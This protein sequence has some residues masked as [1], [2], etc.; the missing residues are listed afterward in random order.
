[1]R[2]EDDE[3]TAG[4]PS[5]RRVMTAAAVATAA[6]ATGLGTGAA[7]ARPEGGGPRTG[8][9]DT[10]HHALP[11]DM[12]KWAVDHGLLPREGGPNWGR[13]DLNRTLDT[14]DDLGIAAG[15]A[16]AP[17]PPELFR[18]RRLAAS[19]TRVFN[20]S[21]TGLVRDHPS[22]FGFF[23]YLPLLHVD[24]A[25]AEA[26]YALDE[27]GADG[28]LLMANAGGRYLGE[29]AF[30]PL[31]AELDRR[32][33]VAFVHPAGLADARPVPGVEEWIADFMLDTT[34][35]ALSLVG[36]GTLDRYRH[37]SVILSHAG[38]FLPYLGGR[39]EHAGR[40]GEGPSPAAFR[41]AVRRFYY[42]TAMPMS[43]YATPSLLAAAGAGRL[44]FGTDWPQVA[45]PE[46]DRTTALLDRDPSLD[47]RARA[48][49]N[50]E[51]ALRLFPALARRL[52]R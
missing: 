19:G 38:G 37:L 8:R 6:A 40:Q 13:W 12:R 28:V 44:L 17:A 18:D 39:V 47:R 27:L 15:V 3:R 43:P 46:V 20:E 50:R 49:V 35:T 23:A 45:R 5:R 32:R 11:P 7:A 4:G 25:I 42:D 22:R 2:A 29:P 14:M 48:A 24:V 52:R 26:A 34:R 41:R 51:N 30:D 21:L 16:S 1:M 10:H 36:A 31:F 9:I 33:A